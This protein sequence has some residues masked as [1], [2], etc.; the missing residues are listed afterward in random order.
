MVDDQKPILDIALRSCLTLSM[1]IIF[2]QPTPH[3]M[4]GSWLMWLPFSKVSRMF[5]SR[6]QGS[7]IRE[8]WPDDGH[9]SDVSR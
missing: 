3:P 6:C 9:T 1:H 8:K 2:G 4:D 5:T 7:S